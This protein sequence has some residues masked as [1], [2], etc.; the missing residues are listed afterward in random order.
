MSDNGREVISGGGDREEDFDTRDLY[1]VAALMTMGVDPVGAEPVRI[2][3]REHRAGENYQ[4]FFKPTTSDGKF[5]TRELL[6]LWIR[7]EEFVKAEPNHPFADCVA[8]ALNMKSVM[9]YVKGRAPYVF[10]RRG[11]SVAMLPIDASAELEEQILGRLPK[12]NY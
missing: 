11:K 6:K 10:L 7:G 9:K 8:F 3:A 5:R 2:V 4:F 12:R 1:L